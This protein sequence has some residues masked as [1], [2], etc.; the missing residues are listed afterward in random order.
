MAKRIP[1]SD[2]S[3]LGHVFSPKKN[4]VPS[5]IRK[6]SLVGLKGGRSKARLNAFNRM[7]PVNQE[8]LKRSGQRDAY[9]RGEATLADAKRSLRPKAIALKLARPLRAKVQP[10]VRTLT[11][12]DMQIADR[13]KSVVREQGK[14]VNS[15]NVDR[16]IKHLKTPTRDMTKWSYSQFAHAANA[17]Q[18]TTH[19]DEGNSFN[20][21]WYR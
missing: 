14:V 21:F 11:A 16:R 4:P 12:L 1:L 10:A 7:S 17:P 5:G 3:F 15:N 2:H 9:L 6:T 19:D 13:L 20:P 8:I 18:Y